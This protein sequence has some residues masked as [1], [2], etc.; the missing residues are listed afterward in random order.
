MYNK[1]QHKIHMNKY[2]EI[3]K[4]KTTQ[5]QQQQQQIY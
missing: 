4:Y 3:I 2:N 5:Q 1:R